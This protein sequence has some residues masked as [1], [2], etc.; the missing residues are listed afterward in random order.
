LA[1]EVCSARYLPLANLTVPLQSFKSQS[2]KN[3]VQSTKNY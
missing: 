1:F 3:K 2:S